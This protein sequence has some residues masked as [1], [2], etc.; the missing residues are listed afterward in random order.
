M[1]YGI[2]IYKN[3]HSNVLVPLAALLRRG[4]QGHLDGVSP[5]HCP[6]SCQKAPACHVPKA[7]S[8]KTPRLLNRPFVPGAR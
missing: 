7:S 3:P 5:H 4:I 8:P 2:Y 6:I 1:V